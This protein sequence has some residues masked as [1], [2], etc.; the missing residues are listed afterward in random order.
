MFQQRELVFEAGLFANRSKRASKSRWVDGNFVRFR[1]GVPAQTGGWRTIPLTGIAIT[2]RP[3]GLLSWRPNNQ[4]GRFAVIG[5]HSNAFLFDGSSVSTIKP[6]DMVV[7][8]LEAVAG[9]GYGVGLYNAEAYGTQRSAVGDIL[10]AATWTFDM[11]GEILLGCFSGDGKI[12]KYLNGTD[13]ALVTVAG[14]PTARAICMSAERHLFAFGCNGN[15]R[16]V[17]WSDRES[18]TVWGPLVTNRA[19]S[20]EMQ[21]YSP[22]QCARRVQGSVMAWTETEVVAFSPSFNATVYSRETVTEEVGACGPLAVCVV[23]ERGGEVAYWMG[24]DG[25]FIFDGIVRRMECD[26]QDFIYKDVNL[27][28]KSKF[29]VAA[30]LEFSEIRFSYCSAASIEIDRCVVLC[31]TNMAWSKAHISRTVWMDRQ[32]FPKPLALDAAGIVYEHETGVLGGGVAL[33]S[34]ILSHPLTI[35]VGQ[36]FTDVS[37]FWPDLEETAQQVDVSFVTRD[38]SGDVDL[39]HGPVRCGGDTEKVDFYFSGR[40]VQLKLQGVGTHWEIGVPLIEAQEAGLA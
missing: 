3:C 9:Q 13:A 32:V 21:V 36:S 27:A 25:I 20:Y 17:Q 16:L 6:V 40:Q 37:A 1:D 39:V 14:A 34:F 15:P 30:N 22:F 11:F 18:F 2:G 33:P 8:R 31:L 29:E 24:S 12:R 28:Q 10:D 38:Y 35:G 4:S 23:A 19:G 7:G 5:T 26:L